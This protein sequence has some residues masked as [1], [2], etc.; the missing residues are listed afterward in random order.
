MHERTPFDDLGDDYFGGGG[1]GLNQRH[2]EK[3]NGLDQAPQYSDEALAL[4]FSHTYADELRY[5]AAWG[6]WHRWNGWRWEQDDKLKAFDLARGI[7][8]QAAKTINKPKEA[9]AVASAKTVAAVASLARSDSRHASAVDQW[10]A[11]PWILNTPDGIMNIKDGSLIPSDPDRYCTMGTLTG[12]SEDECPQWLA[13]LDRIMAGNQELIDF[14]QRVAG[15]CLTGVTSEHAVFFLFGSGAN[16]KSVFISTLSGI[17]GEY[18]KIAPIEVFLDSKNERHPT[19]LAMLRGARLVT[20]VETEEGRKW[21]ESRLKALTGG[22]KITARFMRQDFTEFTPQ[23]KVMIA[24]NHRPS[25]RS[26]DEAIR[27]RMNLIPFSVTIPEPERD[28]ELTE[29]LKAEWP[30]ILGWMFQG[31]LDWQQFGLMAPEAVKAATEAYLQ[32]EDAMAAWIEECCDRDPTAFETGAALFKSWVR[33]ADLNGEYK[34]SAKNFK[35]KLSLY[36]VEE[37]RR[38]SGRGFMGLNLKILEGP[39]YDYGD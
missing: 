27:R 28:P 39:N 20:A 5:T 34:G 24:G 32:S 22:D 18:H 15:Y 14:L 10:D 30:A 1:K 12:P 33:W 9:K 13:F 19:E 21:N 17:M 37:H 36:N 16:G 38:N 23:F 31:A 11:D 7:V 2:Q 29:K 8:R 26:V 25:L 35:A 4:T 6:K 3:S